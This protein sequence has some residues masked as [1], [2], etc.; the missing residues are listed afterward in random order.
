MKNLNGAINEVLF[1]YI[2]VLIQGTKLLIKEIQ[3][4]WESNSK[5]LWIKNV[6]WL[7]FPKH[8]IQNLSYLAL[9]YLVHSNDMK[10]N[11]RAFGK[12]ATL[13]RYYNAKRLEVLKIWKQTSCESYIQALELTTV[14][15][16]Y[17]QTILCKINTTIQHYL[18]SA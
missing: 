6:N 2:A 7:R 5:T 15:D 17:F 4:F 16:R 12:D 8:S 1:Q 11:A 14:I 13:W 18:A 10:I 9:S 3:L